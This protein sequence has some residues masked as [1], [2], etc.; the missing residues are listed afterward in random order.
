MVT[1]AALPWMAARARCRAPA[2]MLLRFLL[3]SLL[4]TQL[5]AQTS[6]TAPSAQPNKFEGRPITSVKIV[7]DGSILAPLRIRRR[8]LPH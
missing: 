7:P 2:L 1:V 6:D 5:S 8:P 3:A 4:A